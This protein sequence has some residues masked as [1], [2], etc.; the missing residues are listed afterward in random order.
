MSKSPPKRYYVKV[1]AKSPKGAPN[2]MHFTAA[3]VDM[4]TIKNPDKIPQSKLMTF[5]EA[6]ELVTN[7]KRAEMYATTYSY[8]YHIIERRAPGREQEA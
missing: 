4:D 6:I 7:F 2:I 3:N 8:E 1:I 5:N